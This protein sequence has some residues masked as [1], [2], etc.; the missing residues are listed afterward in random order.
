MER[1]DTEPELLLLCSAS[2]EQQEHLLSSG[3]K[4]LVQGDGQPQL[5]V[6]LLKFSQERN[7]S[8]PPAPSAGPSKLLHVLSHSLL[9]TLDYYN[10]S[11][12]LERAAC[13]PR[14]AEMGKASNSV[15]EAEFLSAHSERLMSTIKLGKTNPELGK[16]V[17]GHRG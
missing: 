11:P 6:Q 13:G 4:I 2:L 15:G 3:F 14:G 16:F 7:P 5:L 8:L 12:T 10:I 9:P 1:D 17:Q